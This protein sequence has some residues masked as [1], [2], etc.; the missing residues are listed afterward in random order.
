MLFE[1]IQG[2]YQICK[3]LA[4]LSQIQFKLLEFNL[5]NMNGFKKSVGD[6]LELSA[7]F[8]EEAMAKYWFG[9]NLTTRKCQT[10]KNKC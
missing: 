2:M 4:K 6:A 1:N 10:K 7:K 3:I 8:V 9:K 5:K